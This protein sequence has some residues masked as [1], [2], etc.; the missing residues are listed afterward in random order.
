MSYLEL[1]PYI[2]IAWGV[3]ALLCIRFSEPQPKQYNGLAIVMLVLAWGYLL[4]CAP[5]FREGEMVPQQMELFVS[6]V[7]GLLSIEVWFIFISTMLGVSL[8]KIAHNPEHKAYLPGW[9]DPIRSLFRPGWYAVAT[10]NVI[11]G[12]YFL[13]VPS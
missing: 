9:H 6:V 3:C 1:F 11:N 7:A 13:F 8:A 12:L 4:A 10:A 5:L 2:T